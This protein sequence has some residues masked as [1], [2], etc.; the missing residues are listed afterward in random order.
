MNGKYLLDTNAVINLLKDE[1]LT[2]K[3]KDKKGI[4]LVSIITQSNCPLRL[5]RG[6]NNRDSGNG[7]FNSSFG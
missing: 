4:Y 6:K 1:T 7:W 2:L 5:N 3:F